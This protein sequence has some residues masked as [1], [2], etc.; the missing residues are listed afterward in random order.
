MFLLVNYTRSFTKS[1]LGGQMSTRRAH[2]YRVR[3]LHHMCLFSQK[4]YVVFQSTKKDNDSS[5][6]GEKNC[7]GRGIEARTHD[8]HKFIYGAA[9]N[10]ATAG[11][12][13]NDE[14]TTTSA[15]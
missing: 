13:G 14:T 7:Y 5:G 11:H 3:Q 2:I 4:S 15:P 8:G 10:Y 6:E 9:K 1:S 12:L